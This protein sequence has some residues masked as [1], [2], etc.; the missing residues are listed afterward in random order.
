LKDDQEEA[1]MAAK[2]RTV[3]LLTGGGALFVIAALF[4]MWLAVPALVKYPTNIDESPRFEGTLTLYVDPATSQP[5]AQPMKLPLAIDRRIEAMENES[6]SSRVVVKETITQE[7]GELLS[8]VEEN[9]YVMDRRSMENVADDRAYAFSPQNRVDRSGN[10]RLALP[11]DTDADATY[12]MYKNEISGSYDL[13]PDTENPTTKTE[14]M[15]LA[16]FQASGTDIPLSEAY[17]A[18]L[19][20]NLPLPAETTLTALAPRLKA[21]GIDMDTLIP[22]V[23]A[24][25]SPEDRSAVQAALAAPIPLRYFTSFT[26]DVG[27]DRRTGTEVDVR[28]IDETLSVK[29]DFAGLDALSAVLTKYAAAPAVQAAL[30]VLG[31]LGETPGTPLVNFQYG[32]TDASVADIAAAAKDMGR[33]IVLAE[34][35]IPLGL[36][37]VGM[38]ALLVGA[39]GQFRLGKLQL[40][41]RKGPGPA[42][43][44]PAH[45]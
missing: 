3:R 7:A 2:R 10:Y 24:A 8:A 15:T 21:T 37:I 29:P 39:A 19:R 36:A 11:L 5:L 33:R 34:R 4:W 32:Q 12:A 20:T 28:R 14:G 18:A 25:L 27:V 45:A 16:N 26:G 44:S 43:S 41:I 30:P 31:A 1:A 13:V 17:L 35:W 9:V 38:I 23:L 40:R 6:G 42:P 22:A